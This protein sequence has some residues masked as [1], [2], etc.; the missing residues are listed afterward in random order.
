MQKIIITKND[1]RFQFPNGITEL[2]DTGKKIIDIINDR[3]PIY[4]ATIVEDMKITG[5]LLTAAKNPITQ[6]LHTDTGVEVDRAYQHRQKHIL[7]LA[8]LIVPLSRNGRDLQILE[9]SF[10][11]K[12]E[13]LLVHK[14]PEKKTIHIPF[15]KALIVNAG[16]Y[17]AGCPNKSDDDLTSVHSHMLHKSANLQEESSKGKALDPDIYKDVYY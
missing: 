8:Q 1:Q 5:V 7:G 14:Y 12:N 4:D 10:F 6:E 15:G 16:M 2:G 11:S 3:I 17:H 9:S 13:S